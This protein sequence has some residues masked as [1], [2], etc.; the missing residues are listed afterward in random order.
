MKKRWLVNIILLVTVVV[1]G[2]LV[3]YTLE[4]NKPVELPKLTNLDKV[5]TI[6]IERLDKEP[7]TLLK[8]GGSWQITAPFDLPAN[9]FQTENLLQILSLRDYKKIASSDLAEFKLDTPLATIKFNQ[10]TVAF[11][12]SSPLNHQRYVQIGN[13]V[14][15]MRDTWYYYLTGD[16]LA[17]AS[18]SLLGNAPKITELEMPNYHLKLQDTK[19]VLDS[20]LPSKEIDISTDALSALVDNWQHASAYDVKP[21]DGTTTSKEQIKVTL[22]GQPQPLNFVILSKSPDLV[23]ARPEKNIQYQL[24]GTQIDELLQLPIKAAKNTDLTDT[25]DKE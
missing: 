19:W 16:A 17:F 25:T 12:D 8:N 15:L 6:H 5:E 18:L 22:L 10:L 2:L 3:F 13:N 20:K 21:Y 9:K 1:L 23:L 14:Y 7:I 4:Q 11:G 24:S